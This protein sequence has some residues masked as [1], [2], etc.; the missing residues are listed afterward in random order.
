[1]STGSFGDAGS[2][3]FFGKNIRNAVGVAAGFDKNAE[4]IRALYYMGFGFCEVGTVTPKPQFGNPKPRVFKLEKDRAVINR[5]GFNSDGHE[6]VYQRLL[7]LQEFRRQNSN[8]AIG[9][10]IGANKDSKDFVKDYILGLEKFNNIADYIT[11]NISSPNTQNLRQL[12]SKNLFAELMQAITSHRS[13]TPILIKIA[14][15]LNFNQDEQAITNLLDSVFNSDIEGIIIANTTLE[16]SQNLQ[17]EAKNEA[18]GLSGQPLFEK[19]TKLLQDASQYLKK[20]QQ[21]KKNNRKLSLIATG[22]ILSGDCVAKKF[23]AGADYVQLY[24]GLAYRGP[25]L[26]LEAI[27]ASNAKY[28]KSS[29]QN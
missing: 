19:S 5:L 9:V 29:S 23:V 16:R 21:Q 22:G 7:K 3:E 6:K 11:V 17:S 15:E 25:E 14:P 18:G 20:L 12:Q 4:V 13:K 8:F 10:N 24:T 27:E 1:M 2:V 26:L 28:N